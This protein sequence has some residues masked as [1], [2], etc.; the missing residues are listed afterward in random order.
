MNVIAGR[1]DIVEFFK[2][3]SLDGE[4]AIY[5]ATNP[6]GKATGNH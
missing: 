1:A 6:V 3:A 2:P 4:T 5:I